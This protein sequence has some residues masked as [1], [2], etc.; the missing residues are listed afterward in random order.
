M[1]GNGKPEK[2]VEQIPHNPDAERCVLGAIIQESTHLHTAVGRGL[3]PED[4]FLDQHRRIFSA[5]LQLDESHIPIDTISLYDFL[6]RAG[7]LETVGG[8]AYLGSISDGVPRVINAG[9]YARIVKEKALLR[10]I[11][12]ASHAVMQQ[13]LAAE[14][15]ASELLL[16]AMNSFVEISALVESDEEEM[17]YR[18]A[19]LKLIEELEN[20]KPSPRAMTGIETL[21]QLTGGFRGGELII[22]TASE[23]SVGKTVL[24]EWARRATCDIGGHGL[25]CSGEMKATHLTGRGL[26]A[27]A[28]VK[29]SHIRNPERLTLV[30]KVNLKQAAMEECPFCTV[31]GGELSLSKIRLT[32]Q[33]LKIAKGNLATIYVDYDEL[34]S[35][36]GK[37]EL[38]QQKNLV[39]GMKRLGM[40]LDCP[41]ILVSQLR[42]AM[43]PGEMKKPALGRIY[44]TGAKSKHSSMV[45]FVDRPWVRELKGDQTDAT[46]YLLKNRDGPKGQIPVKFNV[47][48]LKFENPP[49]EEAEDCKT[50]S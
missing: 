46:I 2:L 28:G 11:A 29:Q 9:H 14:E 20:P 21:D 3:R 10:Q 19:A 41:V 13:A 1:G 17:S 42:K 36:P 22:V 43:T 32:A 5:M 34:V 7:E 35:A 25:Y 24:C 18:D 45:I 48:K 31:L 4:F 39:R 49:K 27:M 37:D 47:A 33:R 8:P 40:N 6:N 26:A 30:D 15:S 12:H 16:K 23:T 38:E 44:G 50:K